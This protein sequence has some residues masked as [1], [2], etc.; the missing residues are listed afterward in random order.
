MSL[1]VV[2]LFKLKKQSIYYK[3]FND[4]NITFFLW[5]KAWLFG[6]WA[7]TSLN[8]FT[9]PP[10]KI[11]RK[12]HRT[13]NGIA[14]IPEQ[15]HSSQSGMFKIKGIFFFVKGSLVT[16]ILVE[17]VEAVEVGEKLPLT[18]FSKRLIFGKIFV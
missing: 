8:Q 6:G 10:L 3:H 4:R 13:Q 7:E 14:P 5:F 18:N 17:A 12:S 16:N 2:E 9:H 11:H 1:S 15:E